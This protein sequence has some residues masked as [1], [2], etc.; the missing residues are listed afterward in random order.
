MIHRSLYFLLLGSVTFLSFEAYAERVYSQYQP[1]RFKSGRAAIKLL[2]DRFETDQNYN[3]GGK[4][5]GITGESFETTNL[6][7][8]LDWDLSQVTSLHAGLLGASSTSVA[9]RE[10]RS[11]T[12][13]KGF[14]LGGAYRLPK[15]FL[16]FKA[17]LDYRYFHAVNE[18]NYNTSDVSIG[19][20][21][22]WFLAG[23]WIGTDNTKYGDLWIFAG[24]KHPLDR[25]STNFVYQ[26]K[27]EGK[28]FGLR[29]GG[30]L[31]GQIPIIDDQEFD[32]PVD[33]LLYLDRAN[34]GSQHYI[35]VNSEYVETTGWLGFELAPY[36]NLKVGGGVPINGTN[37]SFGA[38]V[39]AQLEVSFSVTNTGYKFPYIRVN[40][41]EYLEK[42][43]FEKKT[44]LKNY[45]KPKKDDDKSL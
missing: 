37:S 24:V 42:D 14:E 12:N 13:M 32:N 19:D 20:G 5:V 22:S 35:G 9:N 41:P 40:N 17:T 16:G 6:Y 21:V 26:A 36:T 4:I 2:I 27:V 3:T 1:P 28:L 44:K 33:R 10:K 34:A 39:F 38:R 18:N 29:A 31:E 15:G 45:F 23:T 11:N 25:L 7:L 8:S 30:G 43:P